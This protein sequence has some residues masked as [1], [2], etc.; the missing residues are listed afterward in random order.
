[1]WKVVQGLKRKFA[2]PSVQ[3]E[4]L[5]ATSTNCTLVLLNVKWP[6]WATKGFLMGSLG[7]KHVTRI[8]VFN[9]AID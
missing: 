9:F 2:Y 4:P 7:M 3:Q 6:V 8:I 1:M 5:D